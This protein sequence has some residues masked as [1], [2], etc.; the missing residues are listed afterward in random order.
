MENALNVCNFVYT[1]KHD[2]LYFVVSFNTLMPKLI[3]FKGFEFWHC[4]LE[5][6]KIS[7]L[8]YYFG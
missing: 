3:I 1:Y 4:V 5:F 2:L 7:K 8:Y 6:S